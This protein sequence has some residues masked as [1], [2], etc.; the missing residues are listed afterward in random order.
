MYCVYFNLRNFFKLYI[1]FYGSELLLQWQYTEFS[2]LQNPAHVMQVKKTQ[3]CYFG[4]V[5]LISFFVLSKSL[6]MFY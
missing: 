6:A 4:H 1:S 5:L 2:F 3:Q